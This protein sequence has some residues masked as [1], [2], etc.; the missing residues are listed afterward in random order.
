SNRYRAPTSSETMG[1]L[2]NNMGYNVLFLPLTL[3]DFSSKDELAMR[4]LIKKV[5]LIQ[6]DIFSVD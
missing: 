4:F 2:N 3:D 5:T 6:E 1:K